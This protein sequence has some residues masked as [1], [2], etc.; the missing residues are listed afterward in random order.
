MAE[1]EAEFRKQLDEKKLVPHIHV[2][3][4]GDERWEKDRKRTEEEHWED[5]C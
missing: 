3:Q 1:K 5:R 4:L 2:V